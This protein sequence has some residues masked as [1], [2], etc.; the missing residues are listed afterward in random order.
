M[1]WLSLVLVASVSAQSWGPFSGADLASF[2][3]YPEGL[4]PKATPT[5]IFAKWVENVCLC[6]SF[7]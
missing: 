7:T 6:F 4:S 1:L 2:V 3:A 5:E